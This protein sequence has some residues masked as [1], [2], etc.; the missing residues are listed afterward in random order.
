[1]KGNQ[2]CFPVVDFISKREA[3]GFFKLSDDG[4]MA[5]KVNSQLGNQNSEYYEVLDGLKPSDKVI[6]SSYE[7]YG[8]IQELVL[9]K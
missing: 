6:T 8:S 9:K 1:M 4:K 3:T 2:Y 5:Y 7:N